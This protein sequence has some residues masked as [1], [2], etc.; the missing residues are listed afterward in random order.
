LDELRHSADLGNHP[1]PGNW[2]QQVA[3]FS[4]GGVR[5]LKGDDIAG[6]AVGGVS[7]GRQY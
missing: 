3:S 7:V 5:D 4:D 1:P 2:Q 6:Q